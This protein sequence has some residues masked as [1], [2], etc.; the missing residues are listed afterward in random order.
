MPSA[1]EVLR[2]LA[3]LDR[4]K[5][6]FQYRQTVELRGYEGYSAHLRSTL[7]YQRQYNR[8]DGSGDSYP[9]NCSSDN[10]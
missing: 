4:V 3:G 8:E 5:D 10:G 2:S 6:D 9:R 7:D 1:Q